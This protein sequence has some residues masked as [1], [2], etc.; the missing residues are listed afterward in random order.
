MRSLLKKLSEKNFS[1]KKELK[2]KKI[3]LRDILTKEFEKKGH[4]EVLAERMSRIPEMVSELSGEVNSSIDLAES[5]EDEEAVDRLSDFLLVPIVN[6]IEKRSSSELEK[7]SMM[8]E[9]V[10]RVRNLL[11]FD[12]KSGYKSDSNDSSSD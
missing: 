7:E 8:G 2:R 1:I 12:S 11:S 5:F 4:P 3:V 6:F 10:G 9:I